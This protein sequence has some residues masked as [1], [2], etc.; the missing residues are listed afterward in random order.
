MVKLSLEADRNKFTILWRDRDGTLLAFRYTTIVFGLASS[1]FILQQV[2]RHHLRNYADDKCL[3]ILKHSMYVD[4]L[5]FTDN[6]PENLLTL[7]QQSYSRM[8]EGGFQLRSWLSNSVI[9]SERFRDDNSASSSENCCERLLGYRYFSKTDKMQINDFDTNDSPRVTKRTILSY[10]SRIFDPLGLSL[11]LLVRAKLLI[12]ELW[13]LKVGWDDILSEEIV[14]KWVKI[15]GD[16]DKIPELVFERSAYRDKVSLLIFCDSSKVKYGFACYVRDHSTGKCSLLFAKS[17]ASPSKSKS[18]PTLELMAVY[19]A[20]RCLPSILKSVGS[21]VQDV[22]IGV[23]AQVVLSWVLSRNVKSKNICAKNRVKDIT[24]FRAEIKQ[25]FD[26]DCKF[27]YVPS[28]ENPADL[29]TRGVTFTE[30]ERRSDLWFSG[31]SFVREEQV[32]WPQRRLGCLSD[33]VKILTNAAIASEKTVD[34]SIF[35]LN[36]YSNLNKLLGVTGMVMVFIAKLKKKSLSKLD[37]HNKAKLYWIKQ[38]QSEHF[39][40]E[41]EFLQNPNKFNIPAL[42]NNL[43]LFLDD[44]SIIRCKGRLANCPNLDYGVQN[45]IL[46]PKSSVFT[47]LVIG[48]IHVRCK[49]LGVATTLARLRKSGYWIAKGRQAVKAVLS[50]CV[51]CKKINSFSFKYPRTTDYIKEKVNLIIPF[52]HTG[53][54]FTG[55]MFLRLNDNLQKMYILVFTCLNVRAIHLELLPDMSTHSFLLAFVRFC[56]RFTNPSVIYS[57]NASS[58]LQA[59][60]ILSESSVDSVFSEYPV[61]NN[62]Q[63]KKI[64]LYSAWIGAAWERLIK[65]IKGSLHKVVGRKQLK[66][67]DFLTILSDVQNSIND[68]PLTYV[69]SDVNFQPLTPNCFLKCSPGSSLVLDGEAGS[70]LQIPTRQTLV[71]TLESREELLQSIKSRWEDEYLLSL[72][73]SYRDLYQTEWENK[74]QANDV[75]LIAV[76][77]KTRPFWQLGKVTELLP[78]KDGK[79]RAVK[80]RRADHSEGVYSI[81]NLYPLELSA[82]PMNVGVDEAEENVVASDSGRPQRAAALKCRQM[83]R[84]LDEQ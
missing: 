55:H 68:R 48:D 27:K 28:E 51:T 71:K 24:Q 35:P 18:L 56:N 26:L 64:P 40:K 84:S 73:E 29:L 69:E 72:R 10:V 14:K 2:I 21:A 8:L 54:D 58:F 45:P 5:Y 37:A 23:D 42:I 67:F 61:Q 6:N 36:K 70:E 15:K 77:N 81:C 39:V 43:N 76:P 47:S 22:T 57:D 13:L 16:I 59:M 38:E 46:L 19:L 50:H 34:K 49:H 33:E 41:L 1:P 63:H 30:F 74:I 3:E 60:G 75:V 78:G 53:I 25:N 32:I 66:Y 52:Q 17:R 12:K 9:M 4:N 79:V 80:L 65:T 20:L 44:S 31:P 83:L 82:T 11:P 7:Y 62:I